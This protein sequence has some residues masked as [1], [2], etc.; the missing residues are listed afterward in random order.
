MSSVAPLA[1]RMR[2]QT[3][4]ELV[5]QREAVGEGTWLRNA[6]EGD[7]L[8][9]II[10]FGPA[11]TGKTTLA[12]IIARQTHAHFTEVS[13]ISG[14]VAD[15][16][17]VIDE[18][19]RRLTLQ[20]LRTILFVDEIHRF[21]RSQQ[22]ALLHAVED[23]VLVLIGATTENPFFEVNSALISRSRVVE[24]KALA[25]TDILD[26][27]QRA[28][29]DERGLAGACT[30][31]DEAASAI[32]VMAG[33]DARAAL[34]TLELAAEVASD[35][36]ID[37][38]QVQEA[39]PH[40]A[41]PYDKK[42]DSH[43]DII[44]A[45]IK[46]MRGSDPDAAVYWLA[47]MIEGGEDPK[48]IARR[49]LIFASEDVGN[50]DPQALLVAQ[51]AFKAAESIGW[52]ECQLNLSQ[53]A[54]YM[55][56]A[57]KSNSATNAIFA[58]LSEVRNGPLR[59]V[60]N[61][62][63]DRH[64]PGSEEYGKYHYPHLDPRG[65]VEQQYLPD[66]LERGAFYQPGGRG[67]EAWRCEAT[68]HDREASSSTITDKTR[69]RPDRAAATADTATDTA[70][71]AADNSAGDTTDNAADATADSAAGMNSDS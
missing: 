60:P 18:A 62:L 9:S 3:L 23:R 55:A 48:F 67:W 4:D 57:P 45:F 28:V 61:H 12:R 35:G 25:D 59:A 27:L 49:I 53:A 42:G 16:R 65:Y 46:S 8:S 52:P 36:R 13:A 29:R 7:S 39:S 41:L 56:L 51:A 19:A 37:V 68:E 14:G 63:R 69:K 34:T 66:G 20:S 10:L 26:V 5:G 31:S 43:Y 40:R 47:R 11:G 58:A 2:P 22:D 30:L 24:F 54:I 71:N 33:G 32:V 1:V 17:R 50:A 21:S 64:R 44:S 15:L 6:I 70:D 38:Q